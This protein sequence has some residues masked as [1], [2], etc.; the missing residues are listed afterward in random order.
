MK[1]FT[2]YAEKKAKQFL[3]LLQ[4]YT[5]G[6][7]MTAILILL[8]MGV[9]NVWG[10]NNIKVYCAIKASDLNCY[11]LKVNANIG[12]NNT[13]RQ[14]TMEKLDETYEGRLIYQA[15]IVEE[16]GGVD[17]LQFQL[18]EGND[19]K[20]QKQPYNSWTTSS[21]FANKLYVYDTGKWITKTKDPSY[22]VYF[23]N[24]ESWTGT[25]K[26]YAWNSNCDNNAAWSGANMTSTGKTYKGKNIYSITL[27]KRYANIIF[28]NG[29]S[30]TGDLTLGSTN[31]GKMYDGSNW[32]DHNVDPVVTFKANGG[33]GSDDTQ[34]V[35]YN[36]S[37]ALTANTFT[38]TGYTFAGWN[39][40]TDG[41]GT[42]YTDKQTVTLKAN[43]TLHAMWTEKTYSVTISA[44]S[45]GTV[46][47]SGSQTIGQVTKTT[48]TATANDNYEFANWTATGGVVVANTTSATTTITAT[49]VGTLTANFRSTATNSL[50]V[51]AGANI[52]S[53]AGSED[54]VELGGTYV[55]TATPKTGYTFSTWTANPA[56]N[57]TFS[58]ATTANTTVTVNNGSVTVTASATE[59]MS[60]LT[61]SNQYNAGNPGY[62]APSATV[63]NIGIATTAT[64]T[65]TAAG[66][67]YTFTGW[68]LTNCTRT[69]GG[70]ADAPS[71]T[72]RSS[73]DGKAATVVANYA[74]DLATSWVLKGS[75]V[76]DFK[77]AYD[78]TKKTGESTGDIAYVSLDLVANKEYKFKVVNG[79]TWYGNNNYN[80][81]DETWWIK[82]TMNDPWE[83]YSDAD[84]CYMKSALAGTYTFKIDYSGTNPKV[85][86]YFPEIYAL[87]G[88]FNNWN[89]NTNKF[90]FAGNTGT[91]TV[92]LQGSA[93]NYEFKIIDNAVHGGMTSKTIT[94][95]EANMAITVGGGDN[96]KL[97]ANV[98][99]SGNYTFTYNKSTKKL[100]VSYPTAYSITYGVGTN[101]GTESVTTEPKITSGKL[102]N[103]ATSIT[104][105]KGATKDGYTWK[106]WYSK[107]DGTGTNLGTNATYTSSNRNANTTVY[108]CYD[109]ITYNITYNLNDGSGASNTTYNVESATITLPT[110]PTKTGYTFAGWYDNANLTGNNVTQIAKGST[111]DKEFWAKWTA[112]T[113]IVKFN[114]NGGSGSMADQT[115][116]YNEEE[117]ALT[118]N[119]FT[120]SGYDFVGWN[121]LANGTGT[122]YTDSQKVQNLTD[123]ANGTITLYAQWKARS[124]TL[125]WDLNGGRIT[126]EGTPEGEGGEVEAGTPLTPP[127]V[128]KDHYD[129]SGWSPEVPDFM[130]G[131]NVIYTAQWTPKKYTITYNLN[132]GSGTMTP[133]TYTI[134]S[135]T[136][137]LPKNPT[138]TGHTFAGWYANA[139]LTGDAVIQIEK[140]STGD[141]AYWA[142]WN[143][144]TYTITFDQ[145]SGSD[146]TPSVTAQ[147]GA[148][149]SAI[150]IPSRD[151]YLFD[152]YYTQTG[153]KGIKYYNADGTT[154]KNMPH[155]ISKLYAKW[156]GYD[157]CIFFKNTLG[158]KNVYVYTFTDN[159]W[160]NDGTGVHPG[161]NKLEQGQM[162]Q[163][164][165]TDIYYYILTDLTGFSYIAFSDFDMR[166]YGFFNDHQAVYRGDRYAQLQLFIPQKDQTPTGD[167][168]TT[169][170]Y[171]NDG[172]WMKYNSMDS[173]YDWSGKTAD[174]DWSDHDLQA[175]KKGDYS[176]TT[177]VS[178]TAGT[179]YEFKISNVGKDANNEKIKE[180]AWYG[181]NGTMTQANCTNKHFKHNTSDNA[182]ITPTVDGDYTFT[183]YLGDGKVMVSLEYPLSTDDYRLAYNDITLS[184]IH[185]GHYLK[186]RTTGEILDT[187]SFFVRKDKTPQILLQQCTKI[188][189]G[190]PTWATVN[191]GT[192]NITVNADGVYNFVL[193]Q[194]NSG[195]HTA[196]L[197]TS[198]THKYT[199]DYYVR[200]DAAEGGWKSYRQASNRM[201]YST[202]A[203][204]HSEFNHYF[205]SYRE[206]GCNVK[207][208]VANDYSECLTETMDNDDIIR[209]NQ[210]SVGCL[211]ENANVRFGWNSKTNQLSRAYISGSSNVAER[212]LVLTG[213]D[214]LTDMDNQNFNI[215]GLHQ[216]EAIFQDMGNWIYQLDAKAGRGASI[217]LTAR[218]NGK[219]QTFFNTSAVALAEEG[220]ET[221]YPV[222]FIYDFKTNNLMAA[223]LLVKDKNDIQGGNDLNANMLLLRKHHDQAQQIQLTNKLSKVGT[224]YGVMTFEEDFVNDTEKS[225][226]ERALYWVSFPFDVR[227]RDVFGFG[228]YMDT[229]IMEYYDGEAR[230]KNG[231]WVDSE[232]YWTYIT[233]L[234]YVLK[235]GVGYVLCLDLDKMGAD[236]KVFENTSEVSLYFPSA[237]PI[238]TIDVNQAVSIDVPEHECTINRPTPNGNRTIA[239]AN[240]NVIGVPRFINLN[241]TLDGGKIDQQDVVYYYQYNASN[242][243]Y[244]AAVNS[245]EQTFQTMQAY[246]VQYAGTIDWW[247]MVNWTPQQLAARRNANAT[248]EKVNLRLEIAQDDV[249][250]D[251]TFIQLQEEGAT[252]DF[253]MN[254]DLT[255]IINVGTNIYT[256]ISQGSVLTAGNV[257]PMSECVVPVGV[258]VD[259]NG[260]YTFRMP[261]GTEGMVV[262]LIDYETN[263]RTNLLLSDYTTTLPAGSFEN[264]FALHIQPSK[265]GVTTGIEGAYPQPLPEGKGTKF[266][267]DGKLIIRTAE[268][269]VYDAQGH[270]L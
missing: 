212:Y 164:G 203:D 238:G 198:A 107:D 47:P 90:V 83:F 75:F 119:T 121:T 105:S 145:Q 260:E 62:A 201:N 265:S 184:K 12:N 165:K 251:K 227:I 169:N 61:T 16:Y 256:I 252:A 89:E 124:F 255:K 21:T 153:G 156:I 114:A 51:V 122:P 54:P 183:V 137:A 219:D 57:A 205:C 217:Q 40:K 3:N 79:S 235:A 41:T 208:I 177:T 9:N 226:Y 125:T 146:G 84:N 93:T 199:G 167:T 59:I 18:Y 4:G 60:T 56:E 129:H 147:Y 149:L 163:V 188:V 236:S 257:M 185:E 266:L 78:F 239:D 253:D 113:Y 233:N 58:S 250:A 48:V 259:T 220:N 130:P 87:V 67:G 96:I 74:E 82:A 174:S 91:T 1:T 232:S 171:Y 120:Q 22:T 111:G 223:W 213:D 100:S 11:T 248:P 2:T 210:S 258:Q 23:V 158:W 262:E 49:A 200:T 168:Y 160:W 29:S 242:N 173:G 187:V 161:T 154:T 211:P 26:A 162:T 270:R 77:T 39:T 32:V 45:G 68:T 142:K 140:G 225:I 249:T 19:W 148:K 98:Y 245:G 192:Y 247:E 189:D 237:K 85:S 261:D 196:T 269:V 73:G 231:A 46:S 6:I 234:D 44:G 106:G 127:T 178:L 159:A 52:E 72:V 216:H 141:K 66:N 31:I 179:N 81:G 267:I 117:K 221:T 103:A 207:F 190:K 110:A 204:S 197:E 116:T 152:G 118:A 268:G 131:D 194:T 170:K 25:I 182:K 76:D 86:V 191:N 133:T 71:I 94:K 240:W 33:T 24:K 243:T 150:T 36:T 37:T 126:K 202:Y 132:D 115:F 214:K 35:H 20:S 218:Y 136:F 128:T 53:V 42:S 134:E 215:D 43:T 97:T 229:W 206:A 34:T 80:D 181:W 95:T 228:E 101:K 50:T 241:I 151:G 172:I 155:N 65:A 102:I 123:K 15:T 180:T 224:A 108:A 175:E 222:R 254:K 246:M 144:E 17:A 209:P 10:G 8:L 14:Y 104:F 13:W 63:S 112:N 5:K 64:V 55:I 30:K 230:A 92:N 244:Q 264:R 38:R 139:E 166:T 143:V 109:L 27:N 195:T 193:K 7:R 88:S 135:E 138:K 69:D 70:A 99:P 186:K 263:T 28:N 176:F 157:H